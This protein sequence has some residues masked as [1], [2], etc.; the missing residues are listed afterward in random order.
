MPLQEALKMMLYGGV[1]YTASATIYFSACSY[2]GTGL[3]M[4]IFF[5]YPAIVMLFNWILYKIQPTRSY[6]T[7]IAIII[8]G[9]IL[10]ADLNGAKV[11]IAGISFAVLSAIAYASYILLS[12]KI[13]NSPLISTLMV[14]MG[15]GITSLILTVIDKSFLIPS[16]AT[17]W[18]NIFG[19][20]II[21]TALP[22]LLLLE[23]L[24][25]ISS[26]K[27]SLLSVLE[28]IFV[29]IFGI[30]L[31]EERVNGR[32]T[33]GILTVLTGALITLLSTTKIEPKNKFPQGLSDDDEG[34]ANA[35][36]NKKL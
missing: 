6:F 11:N 7:A 21:C 4:V 13:Q 33:L 15:C 27:A 32:Q 31:L 10:L 23:A 30:L 28:P 25:T 22:I 14:S 20:G 35:G 12:K 18:F 2:I 29:L 8:I 17:E 5:T 1:F 9:L 16:N 24:K 3:A 36:P 19:F 26:I 34:P